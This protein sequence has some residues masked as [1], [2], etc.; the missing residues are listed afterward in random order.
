MEQP[1]PVIVTFGSDWDIGSAELHDLSRD[2]GKMA[3]RIGHIGSTTIPLLPAKGIIEFLVSV[4]DLALAPRLF[5]HPPRFL[6]YQFS[7]TRRTMS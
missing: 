5:D 4:N 6:G 7:L 1:G 3:S 2:H